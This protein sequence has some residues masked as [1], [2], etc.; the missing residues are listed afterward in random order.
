[1]GRRLAPLQERGRI[2][3]MQLAALALALLLAEPEV[4]VGAQAPAFSLRTLNPDASGLAWVSLEKL[5]GPDAEDQGTR[6]VLLSFFASWCEPC[7]RE[8]PFLLQLDRTYRE[9][10]LRIVS[11]DIDGEEQGIEA[12]RTLV[13]QPDLRYPVGSDRFNILARRYLG[14]QAPLPSVFLIRRDGTIA[15]IERGYTRDAPTFLAAAVRTELGL[16]PAAG[17]A[18]APRTKPRPPRPTDH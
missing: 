14:D 4:S 5:V 12:A 16:P 1:M 11:V 2:D 10:G 8:L 6:L 15:R 7:K 9:K 17:S 18:Q 3:A 13:A